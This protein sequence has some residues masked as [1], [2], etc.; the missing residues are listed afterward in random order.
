MPKERQQGHGGAP[1]AWRSRLLLKLLPVA[2]ALA[3]MPAG[4]AADRPRERPPGLRAS[5]LALIGREIPSSDLACKIAPGPAPDSGHHDP[6]IGSSVPSAPAIE[7]QHV[8][9]AAPLAATAA[10]VHPVEHS[11]SIHATGGCT[12][13]P[14]QQAAA[15]NLVVQVRDVLHRRFELPEKAMLAGYFRG[16][17]ESD[18]NAH[19]MNPDE[20]RSPV[21]LDPNHPEG[22]IYDGRKVIGAVFMMP[23]AG[24]RGPRPG[25]CLTEWHTHP[26]PKGNP[27][28]EALHVWIVDR[29]GGP[30]SH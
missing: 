18:R 6:A 11:E 20:Q 13:T 2:L 17:N 28:P 22:V 25:G 24:D 10:H 21:A 14:E 5:P 15:D 1:C 16:P 3:L 29:P 9:T 4:Y 19:Y 23:M 8:A 12:P 7:H 26:D 27:S 30:F